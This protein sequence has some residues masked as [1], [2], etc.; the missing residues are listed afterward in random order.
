VTRVAAINNVKP[1]HFPAGRQEAIRPSAG[2]AAQIDQHWRAAQSHFTLDLIST[3][4]LEIS[5]HLVGL[6]TKFTFAM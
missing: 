2:A 5:D 6:T 3:I 4:G 1:E